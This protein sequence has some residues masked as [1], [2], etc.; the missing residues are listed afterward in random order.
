MMPPHDPTAADQPRRRTADAAEGPW[1]VLSAETR[2]RGE[3]RGEQS[4]RIDGQFDGIVEIEGILHIGPTAVVTGELSATH[5]IVEGKVE[6]SLTAAGR[7]EFRATANLQGD[8]RAGRV[9]VEER[10]IVNGRIQMTG[11]DALL[12]FTER[13][14]G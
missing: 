9:A 12:R 10:A 2:I 3:I 4:V 11:E 1:T 5:I 6:G 7:V 8:A 13:R 14:H